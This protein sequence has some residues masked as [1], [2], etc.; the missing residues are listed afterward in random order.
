MKKTVVF[1]WESMI[2]NTS[3]SDLESELN[4]PGIMI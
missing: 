4:S 1:L 2:N 3:Q